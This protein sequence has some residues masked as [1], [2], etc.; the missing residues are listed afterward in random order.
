MCWI[1]PKMCYTGHLTVQQS[2][3]ESEAPQ[4]DFISRCTRFS[5]SV[6]F[7]FF[8]FFIASLSNMVTFL[9]QYHLHFLSSF[10]Q[11]GGI[12]FKD[13]L[14]DWWSWLFSLL[15]Y[16]V[17]SQ[18]THEGC[19]AYCAWHHNRHKYSLVCPVFA[20]CR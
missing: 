5:P 9:F 8:F 2:D 12:F 14:I 19:E 7:F 3:G 18:I 13:W 16:Y 15:C 4:K 6:I 20:H 10:P 1:C 17:F 11:M